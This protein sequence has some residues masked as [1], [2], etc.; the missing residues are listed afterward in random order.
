M[1]LIF[2]QSEPSVLIN[3][4]LINLFCVFTNHWNLYIVINKNSLHVWES[5]YAVQRQVWTEFG[6]FWPRDVE[7]A[8]VSWARIFLLVLVKTCWLE[9]RC[10]WREV[11][12]I[13]ESWSRFYG[14]L[15]V[16]DCLQIICSHLHWALFAYR[17]THWYVVSE[18]LMKLKHV[19]FNVYV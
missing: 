2:Q 18:K 13:A 7:A 17:A 14:R 3:R 8:L 15:Y 11:D 19:T 10:V 9:Q 4:V 12:R 16:A 6:H 1:C 5:I